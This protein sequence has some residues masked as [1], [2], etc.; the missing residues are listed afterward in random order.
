MGDARWDLFLSYARAD[1]ALALPLVEALTERGLRVF[2]D[3]RDVREFASISDSL[4]R[5]LSGSTLLLALYS[6]DY[7]SRSSCNYELT[8]AFVAGQREGDPCRRIVVVSTLPTF[9]HIRPMELR[10]MRSLSLYDHWGREKGLAEVIERRVNEVGGTI[11]TPPD[12]G[13]TPWYPYP[14][15]AGSRP[16]PFRRQLWDA[17]S[18]L[19]PGA[20]VYHTG[21][22]EGGTARTV[23]LDRETSTA[24]AHDYALQFSAAYPGGIFW[25]TPDEDGAL[26]PEA[27]YLS[28]LRV[29]C[30]LFGIPASGA[31]MEYCLARIAE[32]LDRA[33]GPSLWAVEVLPDGGTPRRLLRNP[34]VTGSTLLL[35]SRMGGPGTPIGITGADESAAMAVL[36]EG[37]PHIAGPGEDAA[38]LAVVRILGGH[39]E[40]L[41]AARRLSVTADPSEMAYDSVHRDLRD[42]EHDVLDFSP[43]Y[44]SL[45]SELAEDIAALPEQE[46]AGV[47]WAVDHG[48]VDS[49]RL[50]EGLA[51]LTGVDAV[52]ARRRAARSLVEIAE[53][54][55][56][57]V[58][59]G[60]LRVHPLV[61]RAMAYRFSDTAAR[62]RIRRAW[63]VSTDHRR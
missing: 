29:L 61:T 36:T 8:A 48:G 50:A 35:G 3:D 58:E 1:R 43:G 10:D 16:Q 37:G 45:L 7:L 59:T 12:A 22:W 2:I 28:R 30:E 41:A 25:I 44:D 18:A 9:E 55:Y 38:A 49:G 20:A 62:E 27:G 40:A 51:A 32:H 46:R 53:R 54:P 39:P 15:Q 63:P 33:A 60:T 57:W 5:A 23:S 19:R 56:A 13:R 17:H 14:P 11:G 4:T 6:R 24:F 31:G 52:T 26:S 34:Q 42:D 21:R 47:V